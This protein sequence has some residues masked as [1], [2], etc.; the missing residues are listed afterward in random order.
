MPSPFTLFFMAVFFLESLAAMLQNGFMVAV[1]GRE[2]VQG[3]AL[4]SGDMIVACVA[5]SRLGL[6]SMSFLNN[7]LVIVNSNDRVGYLDIFWDFSNMLTFWMNGWL[8]AFYC[9]KIASF[10]HPT[11]LW[12]R[13]R[14]SRAMRGLL[15]GSLTISVLATIPSAIG[16][17]IVTQMKASQSPSANNSWA[18][19][20][21]SF[22]LRFFLVHEILTLSLPF[23]LFLV[24]TALLMFSLHQ[25]LSQMRGGRHGVPDI[26]TQAHT[27]ALKTLAFFLVF[28]TSY[29]LTLIVVIMKV[30][31]RQLYK[32]WA[33]EVVIYACISLHSTILLLSSPRFRRALKNG[34]QGCGATSG[35]GLDRGGQVPP[36][37]SDQGLVRV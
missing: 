23:L 30:T 15:L 27:T 18:E 32:Y 21:R 26:S 12:L 6:H 35:G 22:Q 29:F 33:C 4:L 28:Y 13:W 17:T 24:S 9:V 2:W 5:A 34:L 8:S 37:G 31:P 14:L 19:R 11:F 7:L 25:H 16:N 20:A 1:L 3:R 36:K 10:S